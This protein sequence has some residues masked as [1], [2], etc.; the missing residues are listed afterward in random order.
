VQFEMKNYR[1][2]VETYDGCITVWYEQSKAK[3]ASSIICDR[4]YKQLCGLN[5]REIDVTVSV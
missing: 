2:Q 4:V 5:I 1:V 3:K